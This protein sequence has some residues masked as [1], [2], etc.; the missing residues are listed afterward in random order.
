MVTVV[1][2]NNS[3]EIARG[4]VDIISVRFN[5]YESLEESTI[6]RGFM[7]SMDPP[8]LAPRLECINVR[9]ALCTA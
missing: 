6:S 7:G 4:D 3:A 9:I 8:V 1:Y 2:T 5:D